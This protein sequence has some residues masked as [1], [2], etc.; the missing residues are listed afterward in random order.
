M[1]NT[2]KSVFMLSFSKGSAKLQN[3]SLI[4]ESDSIF[5]LIFATLVSLNSQFPAKKVFRTPCSQV[6]RQD[7]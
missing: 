3:F 6:L 1:L 2:N 7:C 4:K 5:L